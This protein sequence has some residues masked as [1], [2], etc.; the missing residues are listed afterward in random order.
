MAFF[1]GDDPKQPIQVFKVA[2]VTL[3]ACHI[4]AD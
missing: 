2:D 1:F 3:N 4:P